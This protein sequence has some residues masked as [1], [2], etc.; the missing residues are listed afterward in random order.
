MYTCSIVFHVKQNRRKTEEE[1]ENKKAIIFK[2]NN[3]TLSDSCMG[4]RE[5]KKNQNKA[6][7]NITFK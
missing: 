6:F 1:K 7:F 3:I 5:S 4:R 2:M